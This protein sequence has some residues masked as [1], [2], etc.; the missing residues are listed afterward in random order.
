MVLAE[1]LLRVPDA[2]TA[3]RLIEDKLGQ[4][5]FAHHEA[6]S[7]AFLVNA[8][9]W[10]LGITA[11]IIHPGE[12]PE[13]IL[14]QLAKRLGLPAVR[15]AT[16]QAMRV[17]GNHFVLG[18]TIDEALDRARSAERAALPV[19]LRHARRGRAHGRGRRA[20]L[21]SLRRRHRG[22]RPLGRQRAA[23]EPA[24][25]LGQA[26]G[27]ASALRGGKPRAGSARARA[28]GRRSRPPG[29][30]PTTSTSRSMPRRRTG[31]SCRSTVIAAAF[32]GSVA[33]RLGRLRARHP[34]LPE[35]GRR[36]DRLASPRCAERLDR[37]MMVRLVKGAYWDTEVKRAQERGLDDYPVFTRKA[38][39]DLQ[40][41]A[42]AERLLA[43]AAAHLPAIRHPQRAHRR[44]DRR[45]RRRRGRLSSSS[46]CTAWAKRSTSGSSR[47]CRALPAAP[48]R[49]SAAIATFSPISC[50]GCSRT[51]PIRHSCRWRPIRTC[52]SRPC[53]SVPPTSSARPRRR[54]T[55]A[56]RC[57]RDLY[58]PERRN[59]HGV[60]FGHQASLDALVAEVKVLGRDAGPCGGSVIDGRVVP[61][62]QRP[63]LSP[64]DG[65]S[66]VG[67]VAEATAETAD[68][69]MAAA[70]AGF[71][72]LERDAGRAPRRRARARRRPH[73]DAARPAHPP[74]AGRGR[75]DPRRRRLRAARG[76]RFLPLLRGAGARR[77]SATASA[78]PARPAS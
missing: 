20:L 43:R 46:A 26:V 22:D 62:A 16:R 38:M 39:T 19:F 70:R 7:D 67:D 15:A 37:R 50:A 42:C 48:M 34:G 60:E 58:G 54:G 59:S 64:I 56:S 72:S 31:S 13:G 28:A 11:R 57:P 51:A 10:A 76:G 69:A 3:D 44:L 25:H 45:A 9:A 14:G 55:A 49:R 75:Q 71:R 23:A 77:C 74:P 21:S 61:H 52:R 66:V 40:Y 73:R 53:S 24:R 17:L 35:A 32:A 1:A 63:V 18:Q 8:S 36:R 12:T 41:L 68:R 33:R 47:T 6:K 2:A 78:C 65:T 4:G 30:R 5:D 29:P 27:P